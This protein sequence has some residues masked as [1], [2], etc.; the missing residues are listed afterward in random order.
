M[1]FNLFFSTLSCILKCIRFL[2]VVIN[3]KLIIRLFIIS[4]LGSCASPTAM[5]G[6]AYTLTSSGNV[7]QAGFSYGS[8]QIITANTG[9]TPLENLYEIGMNQKKN[10]KKD[11]LE[12]DEF[13]NLVKKK[14]EKTSG[15]LKLSSR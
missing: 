3:I 11:T 4:F 9:K 13:Y 5:L 15:I 1:Y 10:I 14:I 8:N 6:P 2:L 7:F 12:S